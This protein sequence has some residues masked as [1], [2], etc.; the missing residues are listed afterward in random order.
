MNKVGSVLEKPSKSSMK[1]LREIAALPADM[2]DTNFCVL[3][4]ASL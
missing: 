3:P 1:P 2:Q 4:R